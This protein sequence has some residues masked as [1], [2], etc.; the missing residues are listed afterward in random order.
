MKIKCL[1]CGSSPR[2]GKANKAPVAQLQ[3]NS[4]RSA[5]S[6]VLNRYT[7]FLVPKAMQQ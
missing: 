3:Q 5:G 2:H 6:Q 4:C 1:G 7:V